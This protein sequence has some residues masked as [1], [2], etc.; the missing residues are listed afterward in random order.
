MALSG[1]TQ[2][3]LATIILV[4]TTF[5]GTS[6]LSD[7]SSPPLSRRNFLKLTALGLS[8]I[9]LSPWNRYFAI[10]DFPQSE[11]LGRA[12]TKVEIKSQPDSEAPTVATL[13]DDAVVPW[14]QEVIGQHPYRYKQR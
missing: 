13:Y 8:S 1:W 6:K 11:R 2:I 3:T 14:L 5:T 4:R 12:F 7:M 10:E 9:A